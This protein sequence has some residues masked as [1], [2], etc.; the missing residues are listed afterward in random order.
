ML[1]LIATITHTVDQCGVTDADICSLLRISYVASHKVKE[2]ANISPSDMNGLYTW[3]E[4]SVDI[5]RTPFHVVF[6]GAKVDTPAQVPD[7]SIMGPLALIRLL[8]VVAKRGL[9]DTIP[10]WT[11]L[12]EGT[13]ATSLGHIQQITNTNVIRQ[14]LGLALKR[15][16]ALNEK[17][18]KCSNENDVEFACFTYTAAAELAMALVAFDNA[19]QHKQTQQIR[20]VYKELPVYLGNA[21]EMALRSKQYRRALSLALSAVA[22]EKIAP[23]GET[24]DIRIKAKN[25]RRV[26]AAKAE[27]KQL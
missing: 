25:A 5:F 18:R 13:S 21:A 3:I 14:F 8:V 19:T 9:L 12:P 23:S 27:L 11:A 7:E 15:L 20:G 10:N 22:A 6:T 17:G 1:R 24:I 16:T 26:E 2:P 4:R